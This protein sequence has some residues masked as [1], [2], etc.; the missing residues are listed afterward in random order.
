MLKTFRRKARLSQEQLAGLSA[1][2]VR[3]IRGIELGRVHKPRLETVRL[4]ADALELTGSRR[5]NFELAARDLATAAGTDQTFGLEEAVPP[6]AL[7]PFLGRQPEMQALTELLSTEGERLI[8]VVGVSGVGKTRLVL[9]AV[10]RLQDAGDVPVIWLCLRSG[11]TNGARTHGADQIREMIVSGDR[12]DELGEIIGTDPVLLVLDGCEG[13]P[14]GAFVNRLLNACPRLSVVVTTREP[15]PELGGRV[16]PLAPLG[17]PGATASG[18]IAVSYQ[19]AVA[20]MMSY[21]HHLRPD[22]PQSESVAETMAGIC[23]ALDGLPQ[24][25]KSAASWLP[26]YAPGQLRETAASVP[27]ALTLDLQAPTSAPA[28]DFQQSLQCSIA[29]LEPEHSTLLRAMA[30]K[31]TPW[32]LG[33]LAEEV[34]YCRSKALRGLHALILRGLIRPV[35]HERPVDGM[36]T[37]FAVLNLVRHVIDADGGRSEPDDSALEPRDEALAWA[38]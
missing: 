23:H 9:E 5:S 21:L 35:H 10:H 34:G 2:S 3:T 13:L 12:Y 25:L 7:E 31:D 36:H 24:A 1:V 4:I 15:C 18:D 19:P 30:G 14:V 27:L 20:L 29:R 28:D 33:A 16:L 37:D 6:L 11:I 17:T 38:I 8:T 22:I 32:S 26:L